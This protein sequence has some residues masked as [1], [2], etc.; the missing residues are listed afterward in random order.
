MPSLNDRFLP[1]FKNMRFETIVQICHVTQPVFM[2]LF[3]G[4]GIKPQGEVFFA[5]LRLCIN[6]FLES[7]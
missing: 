2:T 7:L 4:F 5:A 3:P 6:I 1:M